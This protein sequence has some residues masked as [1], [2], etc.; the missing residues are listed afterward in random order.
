VVGDRYGGCDYLCHAK[1]II[2]QASIEYV[3][4]DS[5]EEIVIYDVASGYYDATVSMGL[6]E[7][8]QR[9]LACI[10]EGYAIGIVQSYANDASWG[11]VNK[12]MDG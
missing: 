6:G 3:F 5:C 12:L 11:K 2:S 8:K 10:S 7:F 4:S 1:K 9:C